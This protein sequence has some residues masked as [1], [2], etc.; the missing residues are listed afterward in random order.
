[1]HRREAALA[2]Q[3][4]AEASTTAAELRRR[5]G[6]QPDLQAA[7][8]TQDALKEYVEAHLV[9]AFL[10]RREPPTAA[11]LGVTAAAYLN[12]MAEAASE[13]RRYILDALR[14]EPAAALEPLLATMDEAYGLLVT[15][16][17]PDALTGG[18]RRTT[19]A[20]RAVLER[21]RGDLTAATRQDQLAAAMAT[22][23][24]RLGTTDN[25]P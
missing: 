4:L 10:Q 6:A 24:R 12:G 7:G 3:L 5:A 18:L 14:H 8:Y 19:D 2:E 16:D 9:Q 13:L 20:L 11:A 21:T 22:F 1:M 23:E 25:A 15:I 17:Y